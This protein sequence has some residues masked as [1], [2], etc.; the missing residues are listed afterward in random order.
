MERKSYQYD[1]EGRK[2]AI[3]NSQAPTPAPFNTTTITTA[4]P[5]LEYFCIYSYFIWY[6]DHHEESGDFKDISKTLKTCGSCATLITEEI[7]YSK[8]LSPSILKVPPISTLL[9]SAILVDTF[10]LDLHSGRTT[11]L[12]I[13][14]GEILSQ[15]IEEDPDQLFDYL[16][17]GNFKLRYLIDK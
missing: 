4:T 1:I 2:I 6:V 16:Q 12:D 11:E 9:L 14:M 10:N 3:C 17:K 8:E 15:H 13:F 7:H 5:P